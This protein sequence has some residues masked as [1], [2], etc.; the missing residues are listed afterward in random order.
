LKAILSELGMTGRLSMEKAK[1][2]RVQREFAQE[3][4]DVQ[5]YNNK[6]NRHKGKPRSTQADAKASRTAELDT[7]SG[8][9]EEGESD[10]DVPKKRQRVRGAV[11]FHVAP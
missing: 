8:G 10:E 11:R 9:S 4:E 3:L 2:I 6:V 1:Q 5:E 7:S